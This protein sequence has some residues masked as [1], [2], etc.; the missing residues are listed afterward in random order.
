MKCSCEEC[1][2]IICSQ[3]LI[4]FAL[5]KVG[6]VIAANLTAETYLAETLQLHAFAYLYGSLSLTL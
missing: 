3:Y 1:Q 4:Y 2:I 5:E 6:R